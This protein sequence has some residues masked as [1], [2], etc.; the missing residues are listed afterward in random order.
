MPIIE[1]RKS[2]REKICGKIED[3]IE[4]VS[5]PQ[6]DYDTIMSLAKKIKTIKLIHVNEC[7]KLF[8]LLGVHYIHL[9]H[10]EADCIFKF[11][12]ENNI[13]DVCFSS[14]MDILAYGCKYIIQ[15][16]DFKE[17]TV[18]DI[19]YNMLL[20]CLELSQQQLLMVFILSGTDWN[21]GLKKSNFSKNLELI[22]QYGDISG[23]IAAINEIN[24]DMPEDRQIGLPKKFDWK[25]SISV[26]TEIQDIDIIDQVKSIIE[27]QKKNIEI[28]KTPEGFNFLQE[29]G[30]QIIKN[31]SNFKYIKKY[32]EYLFWKYSYKIYL[33]S[34]NEF[35]QKAKDM[36]CI[37]QLQKKIKN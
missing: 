18:I 29:Y 8:D 28:I 23:V 11:L 35:K 14:D 12:L 21:N 37:Q 15:D 13:A 24:H 20:M 34:S 2:I 22:K 17:D 26:Y 25:F 27:Q 32:Q 3:I 16:L 36:P 31:D 30:K 6:E 5:N 7:K 9:E 10:I 1:H 33:I 4:N 19:D